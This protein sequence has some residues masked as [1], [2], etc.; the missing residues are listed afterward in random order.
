MVTFL[1]R[2]SAIFSA[3]EQVNNRNTT[4]L[5]KL[6]AKLQTFLYMEKLSLSNPTDNSE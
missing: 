5:L 4:A 6:F 3:S 1:L 2:I